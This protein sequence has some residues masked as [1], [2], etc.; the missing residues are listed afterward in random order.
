MKNALIAGLFMFTASLAVA[1]E[2]PEDV[3]Q[4]TQNRDI[5]DHFREE[6]MEGNSP[7]QV[8]RRKEITDKLKTY[9]TGTDAQLAALKLKYKGNAEIIST[10][11]HYESE[12]EGAK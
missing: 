4:F 2:V 1:A 8:E 6:S 11:A 7:E 12:V 3:K 10:L 9:C 5:C